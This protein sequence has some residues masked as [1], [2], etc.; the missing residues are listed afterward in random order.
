[1]DQ[2]KA[3]KTLKVRIKDKHAPPL[4]EWARS[5][6]FVWNYVNELSSR[7]I[8]ERGRFLSA[9]DMHPY[10]K[11][12]GKEL[13]LHSQTLQGIAEEYVIRRK[14]FKKRQLK[15]RMSGGAKRSLGW[16]PFKVGA[17]SFKN[18]QVVFNKEH[19]KIWDSYGLSQYQFRSGSFNEDSRGRW[20]F[21]VV[22]EVARVL[23]PGQ[24]ELGIDLGLK[25]TATCSDGEKLQAGRF[26][27]ALED[28][29]AIAQRAGKKARVRA[30]HAKI[31]N[32]RKD[33]LHKFVRKLVQRCGLIVVG[34]VN[35]L[36][37][38]KTKMA[39]SV[40]D[41]SWG[42]LK[43]MLGYKCDHAGIMFKVVNERNTTQ[44]CSSCKQLPA[45]RPRSITG[46][47]L[48]E[49]TCCGCGVTHDRDVNAA[50]NILALGHERPFV[51]IPFLTA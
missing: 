5:V 22:V 51:G 13:G 10:T 9:F 43:M 30:L 2:M 23:S 18:G 37:L 1:M 35:S 42:Q 14:Q 32:Q 38:A 48:R 49:W 7:S 47:G 28:K 41:A 17:A 24:D 11:G 16:V 29:L 36:K 33:A 4:R 26:Y 8:R 44:T 50:K 6:N 3:I 40:M 46:L 15:W 19:F 39:K 12:A 34:D 20:Y 45:S 27:R 21:N 31:A 25:D